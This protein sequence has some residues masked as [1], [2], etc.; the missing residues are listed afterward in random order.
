VVDLGAHNGKFSLVAA[1]YAKQVIAVEPDRSCID[2]LYLACREKQVTNITTIVADIT[3]PS[4]GTGWK[5][6]EREPLLKRLNCDMVMALALIHHLCI[7]KNI[8]LAF[9]ASL[10]AGIT[11]KY[12]IVE[13]VPKP[14]PKIQSM[15]ANREDIFDEYNETRF[16][17]HFSEY[18]DLLEM[19]SCASSGRKLF[20]WTKK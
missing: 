13:F 17:D 20:L 14:D 1:L 15:L 7:S 12:A 5:N 11:T 19:H 2:A 6:E 16:I 3:Q 9:V 8:P 10:L 4:P 18:F